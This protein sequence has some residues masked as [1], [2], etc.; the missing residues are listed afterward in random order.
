M[1]YLVVITTAEGFGE[2]SVTTRRVT[3]RELLGFIAE[4][5]NS[6][7]FTVTQ[8]TVLAEPVET[9]PNPQ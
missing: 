9:R 8:I 2:H 7:Y 3:P 1:E 6:C 5:T 4:F